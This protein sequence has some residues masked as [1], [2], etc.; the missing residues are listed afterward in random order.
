[1]PQHVR[2]LLALPA[3]D[4]GID[5]IARTHRGKYWAIQSIFRSQHDKPLT[6][7]ELGSTN[8]N[9][10]AGGVAR[11]LFLVDRRVDRRAVPAPDRFGRKE[12]AADQMTS[13]N[14][15]PRQG[16]RTI[17]KCRCLYPIALS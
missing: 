7:K 12:I 15:S 3:P 9:E 1:M 6:R 14:R 13:L 8:G 16:F 10:V 4:G 11:L 17:P 5:F 2:K